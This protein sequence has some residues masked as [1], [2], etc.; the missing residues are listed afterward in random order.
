MIRQY[1]PLDNDDITLK[2]IFLKQ[3]DVYND[4]MTRPASYK[5]MRTLVDQAINNGKITLNNNDIDWSSAF[6]NTMLKK[7]F[8]EYVE[9]S[10][11]SNSNKQIYYYD[12][13]LQ[14]YFCLDMLG[15]SKDKLS[16]KNTFSN[17]S[18]DGLHSYFGQYSDFIVSEDKRSVAKSRALYNHFDISAKILT[19]DEFIDLLPAIAGTT[20]PTMPVFFEKLSTDIRQ[21]IRIG[22]R[23]TQNYIQEIQIGNRYFNFFDEL[24]ELGDESGAHYILS[25]KK[26]HELASPSYR[27]CGMILKH[28]LSIFGRDMAGVGSFDFDR[29]IKDGDCT[30]KTRHWRIG[31]F[32]GILDDKMQDRFCFTLM[33]D[34]LPSSSK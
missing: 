23:N 19:V 34:S 31:S 9:D 24:F 17:I 4:L 8:F 26:T 18:N 33:N 27:E 25:K 11:K 16:G 32:V 1:I 13:Y 21:G 20:D 29:D 15:V 12:F 28:C 22:E 2:E 5:E 6:E 10:L 7:S 14:A 30:W 3:I